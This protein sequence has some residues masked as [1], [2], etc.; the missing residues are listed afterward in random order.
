MTFLFGCILLQPGLF[1]QGPKM[2][3]RSTREDNH[4]IWEVDEETIPAFLSSSH[5]HTLAPKQTLTP[6]SDVPKVR[7][8]NGKSWLCL[9]FL[10]SKTNLLN[11]VVIYLTKTIDQQKL[12]S[13][14]CPALS[15][16]GLALTSTVPLQ[17][18]SLL[19]ISPP[20][21]N[22]H[23]TVFLVPMPS[24]WHVFLQ[25]DTTISFYF[26]FPTTIGGSSFKVLFPFQPV[27][28]FLE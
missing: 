4:P 28:Y 22:D 2:L 20:E 17:F 19:L 11:T 16:S 7:T 1:R 6:N 14:Q 10:T 26:C 3:R 8:G 12:I 15:T 5:S 18:L 27:S 9:S 13:T 24:T 23:S 21:N 25:C